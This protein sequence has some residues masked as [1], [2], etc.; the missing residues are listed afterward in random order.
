MTKIYLY[1]SGSGACCMTDD[2][3]IANDAAIHSGFAVY[4]LDVVEHVP[5]TTR[6]E[7]W[8]VVDKDGDAVARR[9]FIDAL[10]GSDRAVSY[11]RESDAII[12]KNV[13][14]RGGMTDL[15]VRKIN[16]E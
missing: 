8:V 5:A 12:L 1:K 4:A 9:G 16:G 2:G 7:R 14:T 10:P 13:L 15:T 6:A 11:D 3:T